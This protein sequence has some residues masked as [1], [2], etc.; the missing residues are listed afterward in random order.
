MP[1][2]DP[3]SWTSLSLCY[4]V[5]PLWKVSSHLQL[6]HS[7]VQFSSVAQ[8]CPTLWNNMNRSAPGLPVHHQLPEFTQTHV[9][10]FCDAI[11]PSYIHAIS[12]FFWGGGRLPW[13]EHGFRSWTDRCKFQCHCLHSV[14]PWESLLASL[15]LTCISDQMKSTTQCPGKGSVNVGKAQSLA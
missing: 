8:S 6:R 10:W 11:Q 12:I 1:L 5:L 4:I 15:C 13:W 9:H 14:W 7:S 2:S 3:H